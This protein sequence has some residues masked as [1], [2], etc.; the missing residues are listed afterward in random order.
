MRKVREVLRL[1]WSLDLSERQIGQSCQLSKGTVKNYLERARS[2]GLSW[3]LPDNLDDT[4]LETLL[5]ARTIA[6]CSHVPGRGIPDWETIQKELER[7]GVTL[8]RLWHEYIAQHSEGYKYSSF[9]QKFRKWQKAQGLTMRLVHHPGEKLFVDYAGM[10]VALTDPSSG[11]ITRGQVFVATLGASNYTYCEVSP[12]QTSPDWLS[13]HQR[14]LEFFGGVPKI[15]VPDN[16]KAGVTNPSFYEP[17]LNPAYA[18]F[19]QHYGVAVIP[20]RVR[21]PRDKAKV[22]VGVQIVERQILAAV[23]DRVFFSI[24]E[25]NEAVWTLLETLNTK[26][27][28]KLEGSR[29]SVFEAFEKSA[30]GPLPLE[31]FVVAQWKKVRVNLDYHL[32]IEGHCYSVPYQHAREQVEVRYTALTLEV[33]SE[34]KRIASH[35]RPLT[36]NGRAR[37]RFTT[38][39]DHMPKA[40]QR[41]LEWSPER[42]IAW[43]HKTGESTA[44]MVQKIL[45]SRPHPEQGYRSCLGLLRLGKTHGP[46]RLEAACRRAVALKAYSYPSVDSILKKKLETEP[47]PAQLEPVK[48]HSVVNSAPHRN[49]RGKDYYQ[50]NSDKTLLEAVLEED[51]SLN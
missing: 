28:Q 3:P 20:A 12:S 31:R 50:P 24:S 34:G 26:P 30:L 44:V 18:E 14:A 40:H 10:T 43:A 4:T 39:T 21:K 11:E 2:A 33:F 15:I 29:K 25:A 13:S 19:A 48:P 41:H 37:G 17:E 1:A 42:L 23:R 22:E 6:M 8:E 46:E 49:V 45:E 38:Q 36:P 7:K 5:F 27:F 51:P 47:L 16:L 35:A 9:T 32:E